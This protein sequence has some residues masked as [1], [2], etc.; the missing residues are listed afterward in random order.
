MDKE[1]VFDAEIECPRC[2]AMLVQKVSSTEFNR[3]K[4]ILFYL[5]ECPGPLGSE[6]GKQ[7]PVRCE[8]SVAASIVGL[9]TV[10]EPTPELLRNDLE[11]KNESS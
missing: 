10:S 1:M 8:L 3:H 7:L 9:T 11:F 6:C 5:V 4:N 2:G